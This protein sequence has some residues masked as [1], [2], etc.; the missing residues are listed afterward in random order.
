MRQCVHA[1]K[2][3]IVYET[4]TPSINIQYTRLVLNRFLRIFG[5]YSRANVVNYIYAQTDSYMDGFLILL[6]IPQSQA[7]NEGN[8]REYR[9]DDGR[10]MIA[11]HNLKG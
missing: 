7:C 5:Q 11:M 3:P 9:T 2:G 8:S 1:D 4:I 10:E 6:V